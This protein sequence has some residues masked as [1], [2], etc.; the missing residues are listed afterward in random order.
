MAENGQQMMAFR[1]GVW[2]LKIMARYPEGCTFGQLQ[3]QLD[4][5]PA[6]TLSRLLKVMVDE[7]MVAKDPATGIYKAGPLAFNLSRRFLGR[8]TVPEVVQPIL[9]RLAEQTGE[10]A[11]YAEYENSSIIFLATKN[12][13]QS[14]HYME[15][16]SPNRK[17]AYHGFGQVCLA[18]LPPGKTDLAIKNSQVP[19]PLPE[20][21]YRTRLHKIKKD[22][23]FIEYRESQDVVTRIIA[24]VFKGEGGTFLGAIGITALVTKLKDKQKNEYITAVTEAAAWATELIKK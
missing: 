18:Y 5:L 8:A 6:P 4:G 16:G 10:S 19:L 2:V 3:Q 11:A 20:K 24:P 17:V 22:G 14:F 21:Q 1:R 12:I 9:D 7:R 23:Y 15:V 13:P